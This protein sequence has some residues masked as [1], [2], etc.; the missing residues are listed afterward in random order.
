M[1]SQNLEA[2]G[3]DNFEKNRVDDRKPL[4]LTTVEL[5]KQGARFLGMSSALIMSVHPQMPI[6]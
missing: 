6:V 5:Q 1:S 2:N 3:T 4:P